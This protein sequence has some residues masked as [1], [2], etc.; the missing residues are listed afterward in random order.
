MHYGIFF[1]F[2]LVFGIIEGNVIYFKR[3]PQQWWLLT[4]QHSKMDK[5]LLDIIIT[6][7]AN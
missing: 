7:A 3:I 1:T 2:C 4:M 6:D 5:V